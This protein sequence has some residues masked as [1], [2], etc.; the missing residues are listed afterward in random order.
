[1]RDG[2]HRERAVWAGWAGGLLAALDGSTVPLA[3]HSLGR[4]FGFSLPALQYVLLLYLLAITA[5]VI[6]AGTLA[7]RWGPRR[8]YVLGLAVFLLGAGGAALAP[9][10]PLILP[11][12]LIQGTGA[13][14]ILAAHQV[15]LSFALP[16]ER[17]ATGFGLLHS[18]VAIGLLAGPLV[19]GPLIAAFGWRAG[20][21]PQV[22]IGLLALGIVLSSPKGG[23]GES[24]YT[25]VF[26]DL[27]A[28]ASWPILAGLL[29]AFLCFVAMAANMY[30]MPVFLQD[31]LAYG[32]TGA[33]FLLATVPGV[34]IV[35]APAAG[36]WAD[37]AGI[38][39][40]TTVGL[41]LVAAGIALMGRLQGEG[42]ALTIVGTLAVYGLGA[43][44]FQGPNNSS[45]VGGVPPSLAGRAAGA[46]VV[47]RNG[48][49]LAGVALAT[50]FWS[51]RGG[52]ATAYAETFWL[53]AVVAGGAAL[54][55]AMRGPQALPAKRAI[56]GDQP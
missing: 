14:L 30:L 23:S 54:V 36:A 17:H 50:A 28:M 19:G 18:A 43:A 40:P 25:A 34:I 35:I 39:L 13:A 24:R 8:T 9:G 33:G 2:W 4:A 53:L 6:P 48:G 21:L 38:R 16:A 49:Q 7:D 20:F 1:M 42:A 22:A 10:L 5:L 41:L 44:L 32:P 52:G 46:L 37:R 11:A 45:I 12:R 47:A 15:L 56:P 55:A 27:V 51:M 31:V 29:A 26:R 3:L